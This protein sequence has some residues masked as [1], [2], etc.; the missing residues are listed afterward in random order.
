MRILLLEDDNIQRIGLRR[1]IEQNYLDLKVYDVDSIKDAEKIIEKHKIDL[2]LIDINLSDGS[3][4]DFVK[5]IRK[6]EEYEMTGVVFIS[7]QVIHIIDAFKNTHCYD[8]LVKPYNIDEVKKVI[9]IFM[10]GVLPS[11]NNYGNFIIVQL[12]NG[13]SMKVYENE[14]IFAEYFK[15]KCIIHT[16]KEKIESKSLTLSK[17]ISMS[18]EGNLIQSHKSYIVNIRYITKVEKIYSKLWD[19]EFSNIKE[20]AQLSNSYKD[21]VLKKWRS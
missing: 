3:G 17:I 12:D 8:F 20:K 6:K 19:I 15:R 13:I 21:E 2:F 10:K 4:I 5:S 18:S 16:I 1:I 7:S 14:I 11:K 9:N